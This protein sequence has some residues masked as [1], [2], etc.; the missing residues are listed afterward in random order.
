MAI[1]LQLGNL[2]RPLV[3]ALAAASTVAIPSPASACSLAGNGS[4]QADEALASDTTPPSAPAAEVTGVFRSE[5]ESSGCGNV[6]SCG[7]IASIHLAVSA[8]DDRA[9]PEQIGYE[10]TVVGGEPPDGFDPTLDPRVIPFGDELVFYFDFNSPSFSMDLEIRAV[11]ANGNL[12][13]PVVVTVEDQVDRSGG[14]ATGSS[15]LV[16]FG[17]LAFATAF[18]MRRRRR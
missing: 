4:W 5:D 18:A 13:P 12:G 10:V 1:A 14:C 6:A 17:M 8:T 11:D 2:M 9:Q 3:L 16:G 15:N 7:S